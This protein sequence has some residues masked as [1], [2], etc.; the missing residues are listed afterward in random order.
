MILSVSRRTDIPA[1]FPKWF[2]GR[3]RDG[4]VL[5]RNPM[6]HRQVSRIPLSPAVVDCIVFWTKNPAPLLPFLDEIGAR[7][8]FYFQYTLNA[9]GRDAEPKVPP[10]AVRLETLRALSEKI[11]QERIVWRYDP[12]FLSPK[13]NAAWHIESFDKLAREIAPFA[14]RCVFS[15]L[16]FYP[17]ITKNLHAL[18]GRICDETE[19]RTLG[20]AFG[21]IGAKYHLPLSTCAEAIDLSACGVERGRC[22]DPALIESLTG[23]EIRAVKDKN[24]RPECG[25]MESVDV[26]AYNTCL[27]GCRYCYANFDPK[28]TTARVARHDESSPLLV[29]N[30]EPGD[31]LTER[32]L[33]SCK[34]KELEPEQSALFP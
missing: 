28:T 15:F 26:G 24:Q 20:E 6:N 5:A 33:N 19:M 31:R 9:Y 4:F 2:M 21:T 29:G 16:D 34:G 13:Y 7:F 30:M 18:E 3:L 25:C 11:G 12:V 8:L 27:H 1:F 14:G 32:K 23:C 17:K 10:L 22:I